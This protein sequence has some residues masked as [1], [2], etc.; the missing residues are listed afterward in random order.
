MVASQPAYGYCEVG[1]D[2]NG[3]LNVKYVPLQGCGYKP[4]P[5]TLQIQAGQGVTV[6]HGNTKKSLPTPREC[7][8]PIMDQT[9]CNTNDILYNPPVK[10][11]PS[12]GALP[13]AS[14]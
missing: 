9:I 13:F 14:V 1:T 12:S 11:R 2:R 4:K 10:Q 6:V 3:H 7:Q 8:A 5:L